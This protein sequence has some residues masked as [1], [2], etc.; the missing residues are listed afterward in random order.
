MPNPFPKYRIKISRDGPYE[1]IFWVAVLDIQ[2]W[3]PLC[4]LS[5]GNKAITKHFLK[6]RTKP[7]TNLRVALAITQ[8]SHQV[9]E[10]LHSCKSISCF[11]RPPSNFP[12]LFFFFSGLLARNIGIKFLKRIDPNILHRLQYF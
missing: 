7:P 4:N 6:T 12:F 11:P 10:A 2:I 3:K 1:Y 8:N 9:A 5:F